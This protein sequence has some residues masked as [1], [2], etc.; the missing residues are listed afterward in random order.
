ML[1]SL[2]PEISFCKCATHNVLHYYHEC[3]RLFCN[4]YS[5]N[6]LSGCRHYEQNMNN[7]SK[8]VN[9]TIR[10][11]KQRERKTR[12]G[13]VFFDESHLAFLAGYSVCESCGVDGRVLM[14]LEEAREFSR[15]F[16]GIRELVG[17]RVARRLM[18]YY[19]L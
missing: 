17:V 15:K 1:R 8:E 16:G 14:K 10:P 13:R 6:V 18:R 2:P 19:Q 7:R 9:L 5:A 12:V 4:P 11:N 3:Q